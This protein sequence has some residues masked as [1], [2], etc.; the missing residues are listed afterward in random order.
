MS[1]IS[2]ASC[3]ATAMTEPAITKAVAPGVHLLI[4]FWGARHLTDAGLI[5]AAMREA[6]EACG[7]TVLNVMLHCFGEEAG[8]TGVAML[9]ESHI[10]IHTW[11]ETDY[12]ALDIF[13]CG[14]CDATLALDVLRRY[15]QPEEERTTPYLRGER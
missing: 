4:D 15:F 2:A 1:P 10:S 13:V 9:A 14:N 3:M 6:A 5:E 8:I 7:A 12:A 11:P